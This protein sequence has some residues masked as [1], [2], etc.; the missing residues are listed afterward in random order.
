MLY[1]YLTDSLIS[2]FLFKVTFLYFYRK[3]NTALT[4][5]QVLNSGTYIKQSY[6]FT[7]FVS[8]N[9]FLFSRGYKFGYCSISCK[10]WRI[11]TKATLV[12]VISLVALKKS[13]RNLTFEINP[14]FSLLSTSYT[15]IQQKVV[16]SRKLFEKGR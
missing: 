16:L 9:C 4:F 13:N 5:F 15:I 3:Q 6:L 7:T 1:R 8:L 11:W 10:S 12:V 2:F 14:E